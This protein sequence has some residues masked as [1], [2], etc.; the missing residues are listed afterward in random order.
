MK[1]EQFEDSTVD[2]VYETDTSVV[3]P[4]KDTTKMAHNP[5]RLS[6]D[7]T[8]KPEHSVPKKAKKSLESSWDHSAASGLPFMI[9]TPVSFKLIK[10]LKICYLLAFFF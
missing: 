8:I 6:F 2:S 7:N 1:K 9:E 4:T 5:K 10:L 3:Q